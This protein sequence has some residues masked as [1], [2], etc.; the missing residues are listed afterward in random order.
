MVQGICSHSPRKREVA[1]TKQNSRINDIV[2]LKDAPRN[3]WPLCKIIET[4]P[5]DQGIARSVTLLFGID[6]NSN[7]EWI[8]E[9]PI[10]KLVLILEGNNMDSPTK[11]AQHCIKMMN[12]LRG[13]SCYSYLIC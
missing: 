13:A 7:H 2:L 5:V 6:D 10:S 1:T 8:L 9:C 4:D 11:R 12:H 3:Q